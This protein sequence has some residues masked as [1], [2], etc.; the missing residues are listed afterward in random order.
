ML[1]ATVLIGLYVPQ[2]DVKRN[3]DGLSISGALK[4]YAELMRNRT[5]ASATLVYFL[6]FFSI[7]LY[8][9]YLPTWLEETLDVS[10]TAIA[11]LFLVGGLA[12]VVAGPTAGRISDSV[13]RKPMIVISCVGLAI[14]MSLTTFLIHSMLVAYIL[15]ALAMVMVAMRISPLQSLM[16]ELV[17]SD[18]R[19]VLMSLAVS[20]GQVGIGIGGAAA[21]I[22]FTRFGYVSNTVTG[23]V[24]ILAMAVLVQTSLPEPKRF[25][26]SEA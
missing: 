17:P 12:N 8:V 3:R 19:G 2:P 4:S 9:I 10:G 21:G 26:E 23:A 24:A 13:G 6:M 11:S 22:A 20:I 14:V 25:E 16:T 5:I 7:G 15:F 1:M 18:R